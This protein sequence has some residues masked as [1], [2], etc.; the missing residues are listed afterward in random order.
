RL[1]L[2]VRGPDEHEAAA[3]DVAGLGPGDGQGEADGD[4]GIDGVAAL[5]QDRLACAAGR[6][7]HRDDAAPVAG[8]DAGGGG[9]ADEQGESLPRRRPAPAVGGSPDPPTD[10]TEGLLRMRRGDLRSKNRRG[11][12]TRAERGWRR[13]PVR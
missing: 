11:R 10:L 5:R 7:R 12:E 2:L 1:A 9:E 4:G 3:A 8:L 6:G 13:S